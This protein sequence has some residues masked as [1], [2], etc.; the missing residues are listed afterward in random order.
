MLSTSTSLD[1]LDPG[2]V[3]A[4][5]DKVAERG[6]RGLL[7]M[8]EA[9]FSSTDPREIWQ[10]VAEFVDRLLGVEPIGVFHYSVSI[11]AALGLD[12][13]NLGRVALKVF[14]P[15]HNSCVPGRRDRGATK[16]ADRGIPGASRL[17]W[18]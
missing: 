2:A 8:E 11:G 3:A 14:A 10:R 9:C 15:W 5:V 16:P 4:F 17:F 6:G 13:A 12:L 7:G 18:G 1:S